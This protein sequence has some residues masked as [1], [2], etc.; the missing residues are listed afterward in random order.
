MCGIAG[1][2][3]PEI[4]PGDAN[5]VH[6][7]V[8]A[9][10]HRGPDSDGFYQTNAYCAGMRRLSINGL[11]D[12][13][14]PLYNEDRSVVLL[15]NGEIYN[16]PQIRKQLA[17]KGHTFK[18]GSD[19]EVICHLWEEQGIELFSQLD[20]MFAVALWIEKEQ[21]LILARDIP[22]EKPVYYTQLPGGGVA[23][24]SELK[25]LKQF[26]ELDRRFNYQALW[27]FP[28]FLWIPEPA[29]VYQ[30]V[31][32][33]PRGHMLISDGQ[34][35]R[36]KS[37]AFKAN[38]QIDYADN[39]AVI[40]QT[41]KVIT[42][43]IKA[44]VLSDVPVGA[45]LSGGL[46]S[47]IV[48]AVAAQ[49]LPELATFTIGF[50]NVDDPYHGKA[51]EAGYAADYAK[52][53]GFKHHTIRVTADTFYKHLNQFATYGDQ[54]FSVSSGLGILLIAKAAH[55][56]NIKVLL[57]GDG[58]DECFGGYSWYPYLAG[59]TARDEEE[60]E[61]QITSFQSTGFSVEQR[62]RAL[63]RMSVHRRAWAWHYY[64]SEQDK[65][66][67][68]HPDFN[69]SAASSLRYFREFKPADA[70]EPEDFIRHDRSFYLPFEMLRKVDRMTMAYSVE[71]RVP[72]VAPAVLAHVEQLNY[73]QMVSGN[74]L[75]WVLREAFKDIV[76]PDVFNRPKHGFN[77]PI[78]LWLK[79]KW[80]HL[81]D[82][83][84][85]VDSALRRH[86]LIHA[87]SQD[88]ARKM[89]DD[90]N[91]LHGHTLFSFIMLNKWME[92]NSGDHR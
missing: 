37:Y 40:E 4:K 80:R 53:L 31:R 49:Y 63:S 2:Q 79:S 92:Q 20:G 62:A 78:D 28:T 36:E 89:S 88:V 24:S 35:V 60:G 32:A 87:K 72:F 57:S 52:N 76:G 86:G 11:D 50:E 3:R 81:L 17:Q 34:G 71:G 48:T 73:S 43:S 44:R 46:D 21:K 56:H 33:L 66:K 15:Y 19:G 26:P 10:Y 51:D 41:R 64:A 45:F 47:S 23:F 14:Q 83:A 90:I 22:G 8:G 38:G 75:K 18:T 27:D 13:H 70:W 68:F 42:D 59:S 16:S 54:P 67:I 84:F 74:T 69:R 7:M 82:E 1:I 29:T 77:V 12:G 55:S 30:H 39:N 91:T 61:T 65:Q 58:A 85:S 9:L 25:S 5:A 6:N